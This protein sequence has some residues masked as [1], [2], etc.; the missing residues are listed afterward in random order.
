MNISIDRA[1]DFVYQQGVLWERQLFGWLF[2]GGAR[3]RVL[4]SLGQHQNEDGGWGNAL[5]HDLRAP[6]SS[7]PVTEYAL[8]LM[9]EFDLAE[10]ERLDRTAAWCE[11]AQAE[12]GSFPL[13][14]ELHGYPRAPW[15][16]EAR[17]HP[18]AGIVGRL[19]ALGAATPRRLERTRRWV[20]SSRP[21]S[22]GQWPLTGL[23]M[24]DLRRLDLE[25][26]RYRL[27][28]YAD[29]FLNVEV[30]DAP[31]WR[32]A[33]LAVASDLA[34]RQPDGECALGW[35][36]TPRVP[37]MPTELVDRRLDALAAAQR[38]DGGWPDPHDLPQWRPIGTIW[39][40]KA[41]R[42]GGRV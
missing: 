27:Y 9:R 23:T 11:A 7:A 2:E 15:W 3:E 39:A 17:F 37:G 19:A 5:E 10:R 6:R 12:D 4:A 26:W 28:H 24:A 20:E 35:G 13:G 31:E 25:S 22:I 16:Q 38:E 41:L 14:E 21:E 33:I 40:L 18:P 29:Y 8:A 32:A 36:T 30:P 34:R 42:E 1:R